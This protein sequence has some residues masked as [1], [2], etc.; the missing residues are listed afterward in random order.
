ME[1][2]ERRRRADKDLKKLRK[3]VVGQSDYFGGN[4]RS[5]RKTAKRAMLKK[6]LKRADKAKQ[7]KR[8]RWIDKAPAAPDEPHSPQIADKPNKVSDISRECTPSE[9]EVPSDPTE[10]IPEKRKREILPDV[11]PEQIGAEA[12]PALKR[13]RV[14]PAAVQLSILK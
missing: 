3:L 7:R 12:G 10:N 6:A 11:P 9:A 13:P 1:G 14:A 4:P 5:E 8:L 2:G